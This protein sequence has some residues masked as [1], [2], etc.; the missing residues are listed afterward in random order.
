MEDCQGIH[1]IPNNENILDD[2]YFQVP[3]ASLIEENKSNFFLINRKIL[4]P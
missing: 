4:C 1:C 2:K 3:G